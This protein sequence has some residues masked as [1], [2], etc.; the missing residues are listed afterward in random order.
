MGAKSLYFVMIIC[1]IDRQDADLQ[2]NWKH[3]RSYIVLYILFFEICQT[4]NFEQMIHRLPGGWTMYVPICRLQHMLVLKQITSADK[5]LTIDI[6]CQF[7]LEYDY[8]TYSA[9]R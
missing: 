6:I 3:N 1:S 8:N 2:E 9:I 5:S 7:L 4:L